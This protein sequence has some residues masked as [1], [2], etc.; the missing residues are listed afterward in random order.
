[1]KKRKCLFLV[2]TVCKQFICKSSGYGIFIEF[3]FYI[4]TS[5]IRLSIFF[6][7]SYSLGE[8]HDKV[9]NLLTSPLVE[10]K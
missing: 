5:L 10:L 2:A 4:E 1:M 9:E 3:S 7:I 8:C 6:L